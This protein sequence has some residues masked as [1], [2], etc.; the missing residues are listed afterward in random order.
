MKQRIFAVALYAMFF[1]L[2]FSA[3][4]QQPKRVP[5]IGFLH[6]PSS[7]PDRFEVFRQ[8]LHE[9]GYVEGN[10]RARA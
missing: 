1:A 3:E 9:L 10:L 8:G 2:C 5:R 7:S 6:D 4:A